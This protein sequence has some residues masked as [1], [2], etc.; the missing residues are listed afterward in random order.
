L[1]ATVKP[2]SGTGTPTGTV[3]FYAGATPLGSAPLSRTEATL[4]TT[5]IPVGSQ[6]ITAVYSGN[7]TD[8]SSSSLVLKQT[9]NPDS[10]TTNVSSSDAT[11]VYGQAVTFTAAVRAAAPGSGTPTGTVT[12]KNGTTTLGTATLEGG[13]ASFTIK[14]L[15]IG[16]DAITVVYGGDANFKAS[17][18]AVLKHTVKQA[19]GTS[20]A[21]TK[22]TSVLDQ[23]LA[24]VQDERAQEV[25]VGDL[26][27]E[28]LSSTKPSRQ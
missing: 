4:T 27:F 11:S 2:S 20:L 17:T 16:S 9:V 1:T 22:R 18:S 19:A 3:T 6:A 21:V 14:I 13:S 26:A 5:T 7:A 24:V 12:F 28:Q 10:T 23:A 15:P 25:L 8:A